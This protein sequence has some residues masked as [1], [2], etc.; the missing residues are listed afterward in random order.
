MSN[1]KDRIVKAGEVFDD[2]T[3]LVNICKGGTGDF[4]LWNIYWD[5]FW[6]LSSDFPFKVNWT[7][8][9]TTYEEDIMQRYLAIEGFMESI[10]TAL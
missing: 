9:D 1:F 10:H 6:E 8:Y 4:D 7:D 2:M 5:S 3:L